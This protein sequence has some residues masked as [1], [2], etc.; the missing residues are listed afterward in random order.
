[1][2]KY[3]LTYLRLA[4]DLLKLADDC[5]SVER[6]EKMAHDWRVLDIL[7]RYESH[8]RGSGDIFDCPSPKDIS[9]A[10]EEVIREYKRR[11]NDELIFERDTE[12]KMF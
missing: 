10:L 2:K 7:R 4:A 3:S 12:Q 6:R 1:M 11:F 5:V 8:R 9:W